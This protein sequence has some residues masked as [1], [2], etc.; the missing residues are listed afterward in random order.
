MIDTAR[1]QI[2]TNLV[3]FN[4]TETENSTIV[5]INPYTLHIH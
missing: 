3:F 2:V 5:P 4:L 1:K